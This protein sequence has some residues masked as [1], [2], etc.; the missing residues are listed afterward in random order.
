MISD[1]VTCCVVPTSVLWTCVCRNHTVDHDSYKSWFLGVDSTTSHPDFHI[2]LSPGIHI[3]I[4]WEGLILLASISRLILGLR[5]ANNRQRNKVT[6]SL[7]GRAQTWN[8][9]CIESL[10]NILW[11]RIN[12][13]N[14]LY[15]ARP[16]SRYST[17]YTDRS[18]ILIILCQ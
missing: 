15:S 1:N 4:G 3:C 11:C 7:I 16:I 9:P 2:R 5:P 8:Q 12:I 14:A 13:P 6:P 10:V 18:Y 17:A